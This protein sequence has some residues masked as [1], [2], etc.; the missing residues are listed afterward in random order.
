MRA[1]I[2]RFKEEKIPY[3]LISTRSSSNRLLTERQRQVY[4]IALREGFYDSQR[5]I[6]LTTLAELLGV[7]KSTLSAQLQRV[8]STVMHFFSEEI[9]RRSP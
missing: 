3:R 8:E 4:D 1:L 2:E 9:R 6:T 7:S 5:K